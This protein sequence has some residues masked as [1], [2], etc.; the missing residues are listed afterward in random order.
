M[1]IPRLNPAPI[2]RGIIS[3][4]TL[5]QVCEIEFVS[6]GYV[7]CLQISIYVLMQFDNK[8]FDNIGSKTFLTISI[9]FVLNYPTFISTIL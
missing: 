2:D 6:D 9:K 3:Q 8:A 7:C 4:T 5:P 1:S